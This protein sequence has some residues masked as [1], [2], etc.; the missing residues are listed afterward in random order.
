MS[1]VNVAFV[2]ILLL[3]ILFMLFLFFSDVFGV[4]RQNRDILSLAVE[5]KR[6]TGIIEDNI[7]DNNINN[8]DI[9][10]IILILRETSHI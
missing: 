4:N 1:R 8:Q 9:L 10:R 6:I 5:L 2:V 7:Y 3:G